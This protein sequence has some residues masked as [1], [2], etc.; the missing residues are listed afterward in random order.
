M[1]I[2]ISSKAASDSVVTT[3]HPRCSK[4][5]PPEF[6][7]AALLR[8]K[9]EGEILQPWPAATLG[10]TAKGH[11]R[12]IVC[13]DCRLRAAQSQSYPYRGTR[14]GAPSHHPTPRQASGQRG[15]ERA[16]SRPTQKALAV[17]RPNGAVCLACH[18]AR[19]RTP[20]CRGRPTSG[21]RPFDH[22]APPRPGGS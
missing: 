6:L 13:S 15:L 3:A 2:R 4:T 19:S 22:S 9:A 7:G 14:A 8:V 20:P 5:F 1:E 12:L 10:S 16:V 21:S 11:L 18:D 17:T